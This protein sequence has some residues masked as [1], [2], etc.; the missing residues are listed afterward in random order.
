MTSKPDYTMVKSDFR[1]DTSTRPTQSMLQAMLLAECGNEG[2]GDDPT[3]NELERRAS[4]LFGKDAALF[5]PSGTMAN[6]VAVMSHINRGNEVILEADSHIITNECGGLCVVAGAIPRILPGEKGVMDLNKVEGLIRKQ[7]FKTPSTGLIC[8]E[9]THNKSSGSVLP[10]KYITDISALAHE[11]DVP[12]HMDG[13]RIFNASVA[14]STPVKEIA[15]PVDSVTFCLSKGLCCPAGAMLL[16]RKAFIDEA[17]RNKKMLGG[18]MRQTGILAAAGLIALDETVER[19]Q[20]DHNN[21]KLLALKLA[22]INDIFIDI[23]S[24]Q[25]NMV[26]FKIN[27]S[28]SK[29]LN[30]IQYL[31][32]NGVLVDYKG[33]GSVRMVTHKDISEQ[34]INKAIRQI[35]SAINTIHAM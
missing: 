16:G 31:K 6:L 30:I 1:S 21:A 19:L 27:V 14:S 10:M 25:S 28:E 5:M 35:I 3:L 2:Y 29:C 4:V 11:H 26:Y 33:G 8:I 13:A 34:D 12:V 7:S 24:V 18:I 9:N 20:D 23:N 15:A 32:N 17:R 22:E